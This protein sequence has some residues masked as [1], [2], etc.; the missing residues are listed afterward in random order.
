M[1]TNMLISKFSEVNFIYTFQNSNSSQSLSN[2]KGCP[3]TESVT[4][5]IFYVQYLKNIITF[6]KLT[7][8]RVTKSVSQS[9]TFLQ[10][11][12]SMPGNA[13]ISDA[14]E[15][16]EE[17]KRHILQATSNSMDVNFHLQLGKPI[18]QSPLLESQQNVN[19]MHRIILTLIDFGKWFRDQRRYFCNKVMKY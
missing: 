15:V 8:E 5:G 19:Q 2:V 4:K 17:A 11:E 14:K 16:A 10:I 18:L 1:V 3:N 7:V 6:Q 13:L 9:K 12:F